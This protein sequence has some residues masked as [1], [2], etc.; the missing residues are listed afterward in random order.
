MPRVCQPGV[1]ASHR[2]LQPHLVRVQIRAR[3]GQVCVPEHLLHVMN[4]PPRFEPAATGL[5]PQVVEVQ[6]DDSE[7]GP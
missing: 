4:R 2:F 3:L 1:E 5:V 7:L 6:V